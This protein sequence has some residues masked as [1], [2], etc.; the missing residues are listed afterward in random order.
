MQEL[1]AVQLGLADADSLHGDGDVEHGQHGLAGGLFRDRK[2]LQ[3]HSRS[4][5]IRF[6]EMMWTKYTKAIQKERSCNI[7]MNT[8]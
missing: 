4:I 7:K 8:T 3:Y 6:R 5:P 2:T 1:P